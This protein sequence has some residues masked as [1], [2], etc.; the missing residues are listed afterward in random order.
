M[1]NSDGFLPPSTQRATIC[2]L[3]S[4]V[5]FFAISHTTPSPSLFSIITHSSIFFCTI[6]YSLSKE[7]KIV[8]KYDVAKLRATEKYLEKKSL[9]L[10]G[11]L[12]KHLDDLYQKY[13]PKQVREYLEDGVE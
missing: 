8:V 5:Y 9:R 10:E 13:V 3:N 4:T 1:D 2:F 12:E 11:E 7:T 6:Y